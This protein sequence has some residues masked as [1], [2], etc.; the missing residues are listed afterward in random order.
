MPLTDLF[1]QRNEMWKNRPLG[2]APGSTIGL[3]GCLVCSV[4]RMITAVGSPISP[5]SLN[6]ALV[7]VDGYAD[8]NLL[9][10]AAV[11][12]VAP[13]LAY[14]ARKDY[15]GPYPVADEQ[16]VI[17]HLRR[18]GH[19][20]VR[21]DADPAYRAGIQEHWLHLDSIIPGTRTIPYN[22]WWCYDPWYGELVEIGEFYSPYH[23]H[24]DYAV[25]SVV[26]Y[27]VGQ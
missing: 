21:V 16:G 5:W 23:R 13:R 18:G 24:L 25:W 6:K 2:T 17:D 19:A 20:L 14:L 22:E 26:F 11:P 1:C 8:G 10:W 15:A 4:A 12:R 27:E 7:A 3:H 9:I